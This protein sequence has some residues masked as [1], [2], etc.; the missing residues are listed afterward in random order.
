MNKLSYL[1]LI[2]LAL[3]VSIPASAA[4]I[5]YWDFENSTLTGTTP[6]D[7]QSFDDGSAANGDYGTLDTSG[8]LMRGW[9]PTYGPSFSSSTPTGAGFAMRN[10]DQDGYVYSTGPEDPA[11]AL[12]D[13]APAQWTIEATFKLDA[14]RIN[15][16]W[17]E[18]LIARDGAGTNNPGSASSIYF[19]KTWDNYFRI[20]VAT[21]G[22]QRF[23]V[24]TFNTTGL[25]A[26]ADKWYSMAATS[27]GTT[28][29]LYVND[30]ASGNGWELQ[31]STDMS[32]AVNSAM[33]TNPANWVFGRGWY[34]GQADKITG[35]ID[36]V[37]FRDDALMSPSNPEMV[38]ATIHQAVFTWKA[39][40]DPS[41]SLAVHPDIVDQY[42]FVGEYGDPNLFYVGAAG[43]PG[44]T[45]D[46]QYP[47]SGYYA[48]EYD[49]DYSWTVVSALGQTQSLTPGV[50]TLKDADPNYLFGPIWV[51]PAT[52]TVPT[53]IVAPTEIR[54]F[55]TDPSV[56][57]TC[58]FFSVNSATVL[59]YKDGVEQSTSGDIVIETIDDGAGNY[60][61]TL[62]ILTPEIA[63][64]GVY[65]C[66]IDNGSPLITVDGAALVIKRLLAQYDFD[67][68][69]APAAGSAADAP[70][71][72]ALDTQGDPNSLG[73]VAA[74]ISYEEGFDGT[75]NG[76]LVL[77]SGQFVD[78]G[79]AGYPKASDFA[80]GIGRG[81]DEGTFVVWVKPTIDAAQTIL[82]NL[83]GADSTAFLTMLQADQDFDIFIRGASGANLVNHLQAQ[84]NREEYDP[85]D[86]QWHMVAA[87]WNADNTTI[88]VDG[89]WVAQVNSGTPASYT[90]WQRGVLLGATRTSANRDFLSDM[91]A[92]GAIDNLRIYNY[93]LDAG[94][95]TYDTFS[96]E[97]LDAT[98]I[99]P[100]IDMTFDLSEYNFDNS[101]SS[102]CKV[103]LADFAVFAQ[104]WLANGLY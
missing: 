24:N 18:T 80:D 102:Y 55:T 23:E 2:L 45:P 90:A 40:P 5:A 14:D 1:I 88:Y 37:I 53:N 61:S 98:G 85:N 77:N 81:L 100:C 10:V 76:A 48:V 91:W 32:A 59:W 74:S 75:A 3:V 47:P 65:N 12:V 28:L 89:Q 29:R 79:T 63:D 104:A 43:D 51:S 49:K 16:Q 87:C 83:N 6:T 21:Q 31:G 15:A 27:D 101:G 50:S 62:T 71:G 22:G 92:G 54:A 30:I 17:W 73:A 70:T 95:E 9:G 52:R 64:E 67:G 13:F 58:T 78:F 93:R 94:T 34:N 19:Q 86:G 42:L 84:P 38:E 72:T 4:T 57:F 36:D 25:K 33:D 11:Q 41:D 82:A 68:D 96:Q 39:A 35:Y 99:R 60:T 69:L 103:D 97:Y 46:S 20:D 44:N 56:V 8:I 7:G 26:Q 66:T